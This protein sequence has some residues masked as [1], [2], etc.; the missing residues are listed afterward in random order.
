MPEPLTLEQCEDLE[1]R[2]N[3][4]RD[5]IR[6]LRRQ[7]PGTTGPALESLQQQIENRKGRCLSA[8]G[9]Q[10]RR[11]DRDGSDTEEASGQTAQ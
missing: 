10:L 9:G 11:S 1:R 3:E 4:T 5:E 8:G 6:R 7:I 2:I